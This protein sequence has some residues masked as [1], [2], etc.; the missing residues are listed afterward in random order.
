MQNVQ[1]RG[2]F[3]LEKDMLLLFLHKCNIRFY[4][5]NAL[6]ISLNMAVLS[7]NESPCYYIH[8]DKYVGFEVLTAVVMKSAILWDT[9][10]CSPL[11]FNRRFGVTRQIEAICSS[12]TS[13]DFQR[14]TRRYI[15]EY[16]TLQTI[17]T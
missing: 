7:S 14:T 17:T 1:I 2:L 6:K 10:P 16:R 15:P 9:T 12:E 13:V 11:K 8:T 3:I 4:V 5:L